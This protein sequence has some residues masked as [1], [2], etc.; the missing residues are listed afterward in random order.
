MPEGDGPEYRERVRVAG[1][2]MKKWAYPVAPP[3]R[4]GAAESGRRGGRRAA[5]LLIGQPPIW[6]PYQ[7][8][9]SNTLAGAIAGGLFVLALLGIWIALWRYGRGDKQFRDRTLAKTLAIDSASSLDEIALSPD[10]TTE[11]GEQ[12]TVFRKGD[13]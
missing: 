2:F 7:P 8:P 10:G 6:Y 13:P 11:P 1:F 3:T 4:A 9:A 12:D 5:P